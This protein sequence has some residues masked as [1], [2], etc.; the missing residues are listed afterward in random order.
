MLVNRRPDSSIGI[1]FFCGKTLDWRKKLIV[2]GIMPEFWR[3]TLQIWS[4]PLPGIAG[5]LPDWR[6]KNESWRIPS[7]VWRNKH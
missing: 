3:N 5:K 2:G 7:R 6:N 1:R 4:D